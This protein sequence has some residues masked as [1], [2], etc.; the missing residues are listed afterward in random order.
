M[1][2][3]DISCL[4][5]DQ[6]CI[7][8]PQ[9]L[10]EVSKRSHGPRPPIFPYDWSPNGGQV[11]MAAVG[12]KGKDDIFVGDWDGRNWVNLTNSPDY[13]SNPTWVPDGSRI[14]YIASS[15]EPDNSFHAYTMT[16][17]G[18]KASQLLSTLTL[19]GVGVL[20]W[21]PDGR[22]VVFAYSD[23]KGYYQLFL[24]N[25][26][27]SDLR[28]LTYEEENHGLY[29]FSPDGQWILYT[30]ETETGA[31]FNNIYRIQIDGLDKVAVTQST[32]GI[33]SNLA[34]APGGDWIAFTSKM[35]GNYD[36]YLI[37]VDGTGLTKIT[38]SNADEFAPAWRTLSP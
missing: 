20:Y 30:L 3:V 11:V 25:P 32:K 29:G 19:S 31:S 36:V 24:A 28:Q 6:P 5:S 26:D 14:T 15:G 16:L 27:G 9:L 10:F 18:K 34:W 38:H 35:E 33:K 8:E 4:E 21:A 2:A 13:E 12:F 7:G 17:D 37:R 23:V 22:Q 1:Y